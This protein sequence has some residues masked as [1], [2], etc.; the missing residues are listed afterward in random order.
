M[1]KFIVASLLVV[2][3]GVLFLGSGFTGSV[4][5]ADTP[6]AAPQVNAP[7]G[8]GAGK[9]GGYRAAEGGL[10]TI[11]A[12]MTGLTAEEIAAQRVEGNSLAAIASAQGVSKEQLVE[13]AIAGRKAW[14]NSLVEQGTM[15]AEV[16]EA[17]LTIMEQRV[18]EQLERTDVG[19]GGRGR[20]KGFG[21][22]RGSGAGK[23]S[24]LNFR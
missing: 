4:Q 5:A 24:C 8:L 9:G 13:K 12:A 3:T 2:M 22:G 23:G 16:A 1:K 10:R 6:E 21:G 11:V 15:T 17:R 20:G 19:P 14:L 18:S 7:A